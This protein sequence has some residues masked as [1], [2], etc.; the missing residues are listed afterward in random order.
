MR[1]PSIRWV[2][3]SPVFRLPWFMY[4]R[5]A[6]AVRIQSGRLVLVIPLWWHPAVKNLPGYGWKPERSKRQQ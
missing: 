5:L 3:P 2:E 1:W 6:N 4:H